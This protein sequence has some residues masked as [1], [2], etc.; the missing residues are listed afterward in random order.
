MIDSAGISAFSDCPREK[1]TSDGE[2]LG[3]AGDKSAL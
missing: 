3:S 1:V 2:R